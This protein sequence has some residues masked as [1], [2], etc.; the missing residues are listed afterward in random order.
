MRVKCSARSEIG[1]KVQRF[2]LNLG[3]AYLEKLPY[4]VVLRGWPEHGSLASCRSELVY[5]NLHTL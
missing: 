2:A 4:G 3:I 1:F 5:G